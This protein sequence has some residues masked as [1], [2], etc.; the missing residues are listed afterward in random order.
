M[1]DSSNHRTGRPRAVA[2]FMRAAV[3]QARDGSPE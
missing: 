2:S 3:L 1:T